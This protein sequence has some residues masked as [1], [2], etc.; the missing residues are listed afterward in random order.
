MAMSDK[1]DW[2]RSKEAELAS[3]AQAAATRRR[4]R[5]LQAQS[6]SSPAGKKRRNKPAYDVIR[7]VCKEHHLVVK[8]HLDEGY[9]AFFGGYGGWED[10]ARP[11]QVSATVYRG[12]RAPQLRLRLILGGWPKQ[13]P[14]T[15]C[16]RDMRRLDHMARLPWDRT[17]DRPPLVRVRGQVPHHH[18]RWFLEKLE[19]GDVDVVRNTRVRA[20]VTVTLRMYVPVELV[21]RRDPVPRPTRG[22]KVRAGE[23][24]RRIVKEELDL[25]TAAEIRMAIRRVLELNGLKQATEVRADRTI[26]LPVGNWWRKEARKSVG[27]K[28][29][30]GGGVGAAITA[31]R[32]KSPILP[33]RRARR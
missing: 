6:K 13:P 9:P 2:K 23:T 25:D 21:K 16:E 8:A 28:W 1:R 19:W 10:E 15:D 29:A 32:P 31:P 26:K 33:P 27:T 18:R 17:D 11:G 30:V 20:F 3:S 24:L 4:E 7:L 14:G 12:S 22:Y 5:Q